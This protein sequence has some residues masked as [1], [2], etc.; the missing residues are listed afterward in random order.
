[1]TASPTGTIRLVTEL[2][3][4]RKSESDVPHCCRLDLAVAP[5][6]L[7]AEFDPRLWSRFDRD[8]GEDRR[9]F[10]VVG[11]FDFSEDGPRPVLES[12]PATAALLA[13]LP[14]EVRRVHYSVLPPRGVAVPHRDGQSAEISAALFERTLR[15]H[16]PVTTTSLAWIFCDDAFYQLPIGGLYQ[17]H[18]RVTHGAMNLHPSETRVHLIVDV[19]PDEALLALLPAAASIAPATDPSLGVRYRSA[20]TRREPILR[21]KRALLDVWERLVP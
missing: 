10:F 5:A 19:A 1:M 11:T 2:P 8:P 13:S 18:N 9:R 3:R 16:I 20:R 21:A 15:L 14:G 7:A 4:F 6:P 12:L 17:L